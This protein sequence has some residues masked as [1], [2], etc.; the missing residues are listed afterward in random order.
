MIVLNEEPDLSDPTKYAL[1][2]NAKRG[3][4]VEVVG[5]LA[6]SNVNSDLAVLAPDLI[7]TRLWNSNVTNARP[8]DVSMSDVNRNNSRASPGGLSISPSESLI[9]WDVT[10]R[11][12]PKKSGPTVNTIQ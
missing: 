11:L 12:A 6:R 5:D 9:R 10:D 4:K 2:Q 7:R 3:D 8:T 1:N